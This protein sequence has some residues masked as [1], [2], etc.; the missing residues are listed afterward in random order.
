[1]HKLRNT[2]HIAILNNLLERYGESYGISKKML[3]RILQGFKWDKDKA[4]KEVEDGG[5]KYWYSDE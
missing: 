3:R 4:A 1:M 5:W 2:L